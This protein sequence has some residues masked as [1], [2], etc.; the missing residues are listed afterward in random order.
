MPKD[1]SPQ[2]TPIN[3][4]VKAAT[5]AALDAAADTVADAP[6]DNAGKIEG[7]ASR[8]NESNNILIALSS[9]PSVDELSAAIGLSIYLDKMGKR[10]TAIYSGETP[11]ALEFLK[12]EDTFERTA[13]TLQDF[14]IAINKDKADHLRY[15]LDGDFVKVY[16]TPYGSKISEED[17][18]FSYGDYNVDLVIAL[19][20]ANGIDLDSALREHGRIMH[21]ASIVNITTGKPGKFGEIEWSEPAMS[22]ISEIVA[23]LSY[24]LK[25]VPVEKDEA[26]AYLTGIVAATNR[27]SNANTTPDTMKMA[28]RLM[29]SG[30]NQQL[31]AKNIT[32]EIEN[33][34]FNASS[35]ETPAAPAVVEEPIVKE[36]NTDIEIEHTEEVP[37][38][39]NSENDLLSDLDAARATLAGAGAEVVQAEQ[40]KPLQVSGEAAEG[41]DEAAA[42]MMNATFSEIPDETPRVEAPTIEPSIHGPEVVITPPE[43]L[44][45]TTVEEEKNKYGEM[46]TEALGDNPAAVMAPVVSDATEVPAVPVDYGAAAVV[47][48]A[49]DL[50]PPPPAPT[51][52]MGMAPEMPAPMP[53]MPAPAP[54]PEPMPAPMPVAPAPVVPEPVVSAPA[55][56]PIAPAPVP[57]VPAVAPMPAPE[58]A[59]DPAA[60]RIPGM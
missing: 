35:A 31:I 13:D 30:A 32:P 12:P 53:E 18:E 23:T 52:P 37:V 14:V 33:E 27:F 11:D 26:T 19:D 24:E 55:P 6:V 1:N 49:P 22:S 57:P 10:A 47:A 41:L 5:D 54:M 56:E 16:I 34:I 44:N 8:I 3:D 51:M 29:E 21:D 4:N 60:F 7:I 25:D 28:S 38:D 59:Y 50:L 17:L 40:E 48:P 15:K 46:I 42:E 45:T 20:V 36:D 58:Q 9:N 43:N 2:N 39:T